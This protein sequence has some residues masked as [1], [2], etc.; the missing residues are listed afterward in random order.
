MA[1]NFFL[2]NPDLQF[3]LE[4]LDLTEVVEI[5][6]QGYRYASEYPA[7]PRHYRDAKDNY[8][9]LLEV[10]GELCANVVAPHAT[11]ADEVGVQFQDGQVSYAPVTQEAIDSLR[12]AGLM[13]VMLPWERGGMNLPESIYQMMVEV[14]SRAEAGLMTIFGLQEIASAINEYGDEAMKERILPRFSRGE[15]TGAMVLTEPDV[16]SDLGSVQTKATL[17]EATGKWTLNGVKRFIT[18]GNADIHLVL[19]RSEEGST[20]AR[21]LSFFLVERDET[22]RIR[23]IENKMGLHASPTCEIQYHNTPA[24]LLGKRRYG[25]MRY[26]MSLMNGARLA[27]GAQA[28]GIAEAAYREA[29]R[30]AS[31][32]KQF[33]GPI[34]QLP[35]VARMLLTMRGEI[36]AAR[37]LIAETGRWVDLLKAYDQLLAENP[38]PDPLVRQK[39][40][41][42]S[43][44]AD[45]L[46][47]LTKYYATEM[48]N[49]VC[50]LAMQIHGGV[51]YMREFNVE[52]HYRDVRVTNIYEGT[53]QLQIVAAQGKL[54]G[55][56]LDGLLDQWSAMEVD[57]PLLPLHARL[58]EATDLFKQATDALKAQSRE[59]V[60]YYASD[61]AD[62][63]VHLSGGW[64]LLKDAQ[65]ENRK[66]EL[67]R[68]YLAQHLP[69]IRSK[70]EVL[71]QADPAGL[72]AMEAI[73]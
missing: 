72:Q 11:E 42:A 73:L 44:L 33:G 36:E 2:D 60:D 52:R 38:T 28:L 25:L 15:V 16:G 31:Q 4:Q 27:V 51:G 40:K 8:R 39:Q 71:L 14:A 22:V 26:A 64:L 61:L 21:G 10:L 35:A 12:Q 49:R 50:Y 54:L 34:R 30:Y 6:E 1:D 32:R 69:E 58:L 56:A 59:M 43:S 41:A 5:K 9:L 45:T 70:S 63:A 67:L 19:A 37:A 20:D 46:T 24:E 17:D 65:L 66:L 7:A 55:H 47:P 23:R 57:E 29:Y 13:G 48:G 68:V 18:N 62:M 53:S 3:R